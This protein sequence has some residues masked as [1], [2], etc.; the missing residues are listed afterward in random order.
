M[1]SLGWVGLEP[2][3]WLR[4]YGASEDS[5]LS[6]GLALKLVEPLGRASAH[7]TEAMM[8]IQPLQLTAAACRLSGFNFSRRRGR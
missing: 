4:R 8:S 2:A 1:V 5:T 6:R 3:S 7:P